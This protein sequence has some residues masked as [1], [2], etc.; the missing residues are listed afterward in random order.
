MYV[1]IHLGANDEKCSKLAHVKK[2]DVVKMVKKQGLNQQKRNLHKMC[3][4]SY[5]VIESLR[6]I[7]V[8]KT[9][10]YLPRPINWRL[11]AFGLIF[12]ITLYSEHV[13]K[14]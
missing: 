5:V 2:R 7:V 11:F 3:I 4:C 8:R 12:N 9:G 13:K 1:L 14:K 10:W 6:S